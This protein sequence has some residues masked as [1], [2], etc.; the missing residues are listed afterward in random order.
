MDIELMLEKFVKSVPLTSAF[1]QEGRLKKIHNGQALS[2]ILSEQIAK[3]YP[4]DGNNLRFLITPEYLQFGF[5]RLEENNS[6][7][8]LGPASPYEPTLNQIN[9]FLST[10]KI[11]RQNG[12]D[13]AGWFHHIL[14]MDTPRFRNLLEFLYYILTGNSE[15][16]LRISYHATKMTTVFHAEDFSITGHSFHN[17]ENLS[18]SCIRY[19]L[20][21]KLES[22]IRKDFNEVISPEL[23]P[24]AIRSLKNALIS[25][26]AVACRNAIQGGLSYDTAISLSDYYIAQAEKLSIYADIKQTIENMLLDYA[27]R[28]SIIQ[29]FH[30]DSATVNSICRYINAHISNKITVAEISGAVS[31]NAS[32]ISHHFKE[33]TG[34]SISDYINIQK[35]KE[36]KHLLES[37]NLSLS[38]ISEKLA[39][40]SQQYFQKIF[41]KQAGITP[42]QYKKEQR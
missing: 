17:L 15:E 10:Y 42:L 26:T 5:I 40:S 18:A 13:A 16:P 29:S 25:A 30:S 8:V 4:P 34:Y 7:L 33:K 38:E 14:V 22:M 31:L 24:S 27:K 1:Y 6:F 39:F 36:A 37:T 12:A 11:P 32:Y 23:A 28:V 9:T 20:Y 3:E 41:K 2:N 19:G 35:V 21:D